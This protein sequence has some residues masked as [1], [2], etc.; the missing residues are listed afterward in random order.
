MLK[1]FWDEE[2]EASEDGLSHACGCY[3]F[4]IRAGRGTKPWYVGQ[5]N[6]QTFR[7]ECLTEHKRGTYNDLLGQRSG[8]PLLFLV[9]RR[10]A[11]GRRFSKPSGTG[12]RDVDFLENT[13]IQIGLRRNGHLCN[14][15]NTKMNRN[16]LV[17]GIMNPTRGNPGE[18]VTALKEILGL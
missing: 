1:P 8:R 4:A 13:L 15:Q 5:S 3:L 11:T 14:S 18:P 9:A 7:K 6:K 12:Y 16:M 10:T 17:P 2:V